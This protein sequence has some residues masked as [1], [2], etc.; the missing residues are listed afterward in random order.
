MAETVTQA[1]FPLFTLCGRRGNELLP[2]PHPG[3]QAASGRG[4]WCRALLPAT[5]SRWKL[6]DPPHPRHAIPVP[7]PS[8]A[9]VFPCFLYLCLVSCLFGSHEPLECKDTG[10][11]LPCSGS[12]S[13]LDPHPRSTRYAIQPGRGGVSNRKSPVPKLEKPYAHLASAV[14]N[15]HNPCGFAQ[16]GG[17]RRWHYLHLTDEERGWGLAMLCSW[18][19]TEGSGL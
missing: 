7:C 3:S 13:H 15:L 8:Q 12:F 10:H 18:A 6:S 4:C 1:V 11:F 5:T 2:H 16:S 19:R 9:P 17:Q 14:C